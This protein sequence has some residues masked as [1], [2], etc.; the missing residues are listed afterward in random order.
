MTLPPRDGGYPR[1]QLDRAGCAGGGGAAADQ[2]R[3]LRPVLIEAGPTHVRGIDRS[4]RGR[5]PQARDLPSGRAGY[6][7]RI[8]GPSA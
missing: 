2:Q 4:R 5:G 7:V 6:R 3:P 1:G 8:P